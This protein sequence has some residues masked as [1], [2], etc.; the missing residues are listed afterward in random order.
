MATSDDAYYLAIIKP[1]AQNDSHDLVSVRTMKK[2]E[3]ECYF[4]SSRFLTP[5]NKPSQ[6]RPF[7]VG[8]QLSYAN[9]IFGKMAAFQSKDQRQCPKHI[10]CIK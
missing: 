7:A 6:R 4:P 9:I 5:F 3:E 1:K 8:D 10:C 2:C